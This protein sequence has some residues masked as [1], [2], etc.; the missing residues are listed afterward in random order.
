LTLHN[1]IHRYLPL[2]TQ[3]WYHLNSYVCVCMYVCAQRE[4]EWKGSF[5]ST[6]GPRLI[7]K[8]RLAPKCYV[9]KVGH[10][11]P[12]GVDVKSEWSYTPMLSHLHCVCMKGNFIFTAAPAT[13]SIRSSSEHALRCLFL[14]ICKKEPN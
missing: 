11:P 10:A 7:L 12:A 3:N 9:P 13:S 8:P 6:K 14:L 5:I 1:V 2:T 4:R